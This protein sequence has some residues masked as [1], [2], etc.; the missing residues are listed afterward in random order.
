MNS[1]TTTTSS[2]TSTSITSSS[3]A[4]QTTSTTQMTT[5]TSLNNA[6]YN[7]VMKF[8]QTYNSSYANLSSAA[9]LSFIS[10]YNAFVRILFY[11][12]ITV[13]TESM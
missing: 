3:T 10:Y 9:S 5:T 2:L 6:I 11:L 8:S 13:T 7:V 12:K 1:V 4:L